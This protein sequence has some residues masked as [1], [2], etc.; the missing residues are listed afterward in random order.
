MGSKD[1]ISGLDQIAA[2]NKSNAI[3]I[4]IDDTPISS[5]IAE[6]KTLLLGEHAPKLTSKIVDVLVD[7]LKAGVEVGSIEPSAARGTHELR[8]SLKFTNCFSE[9]M[10]TL[11][12]R[13]VD[14]GVR[15]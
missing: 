10:T 2:R 9:L 5:D 12:T 3:N 15:I 8:I 1:R 14:A 11:G 13:D 6:I 4:T 7:F